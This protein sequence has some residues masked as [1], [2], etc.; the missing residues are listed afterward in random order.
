MICRKCGKDKLWIPN[1]PKNQEYV[2]EC[3]LKKGMD[4]SINIMEKCIE[5]NK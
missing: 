2:C 5:E 3:E 1:V 4:E